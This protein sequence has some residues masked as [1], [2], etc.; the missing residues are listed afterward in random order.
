MLQGLIS[1]LPDFS[2]LSEIRKLSKVFTQPHEHYSSSLFFVF[3]F[4]ICWI[5][6][7]MKILNVPT[8]EFGTYSHFQKPCCRELGSHFPQKLRQIA[9]KPA[10]I[11]KVTFERDSRPPLERTTGRSILKLGVKRRRKKKEKITQSRKSYTSQ[12]ST[13]Y[14]RNTGSIRSKKKNWI[15]SETHWTAHNSIRKTR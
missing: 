3:F 4:F 14:M 8:S 2:R 7:I 11:I 9:G 1:K 5:N 6:T 12:N 10:S 13:S 15:P